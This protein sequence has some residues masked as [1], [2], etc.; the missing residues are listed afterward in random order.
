MMLTDLE[1]CYDGIW[2]QGLY[3]MLSSM[4]VEQSFLLNIKAWLENTVMH[5]EWNGVTGPP[6]TPKEGLKQGCVLSPNAHPL[7]RV[8]ELR[9]GLLTCRMCPCTPGSCP[10]R[11]RRSRLGRG[12]VP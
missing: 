10:W 7:H 5:P 2:R 1:K 9:H 12:Q 4:G 11:K 6:V 3:L 8:H